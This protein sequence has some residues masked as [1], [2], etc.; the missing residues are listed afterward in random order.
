[1]T[2][3]RIQRNGNPP[4]LRDTP[5]TQLLAGYFNVFRLNANLL[6]IEFYFGKAKMFW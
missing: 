2:H 6:S 4:F 1:V 3:E 5:I